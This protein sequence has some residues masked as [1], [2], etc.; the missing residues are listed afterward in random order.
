MQLPFQGKLVIL[1][2]EHRWLTVELQAR[3]PVL[4]PADGV[5]FRVV[6]RPG[7][8]GMV[9]EIQHGDTTSW[10]GCLDSVLIPPIHQVAAGD[11]VG[12]SGWDQVGLPCLRWGVRDNRTGEWLDA[13]ALTVA[14]EADGV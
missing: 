13:L 7:G 1:P 14:F 3:T 10:I 12:W 9:L 2:T 6:Q 5:A 11:Q 8:W 4:A